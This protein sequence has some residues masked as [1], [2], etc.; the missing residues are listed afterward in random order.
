MVV[1]LVDS[2]GSHRLRGLVEVA[3]LASQLEVGHVVEAAVVKR[4]DVVEVGWFQH[5][6]QT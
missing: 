1:A 2:A 4:H 5:A 3:I 6:D